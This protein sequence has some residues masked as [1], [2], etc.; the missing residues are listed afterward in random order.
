MNERSTS[1]SQLTLR[2]SMKNIVDDLKE[3]RLTVTTVI[4]EFGVI[5]LSALFVVLRSVIL[6]F[7]KWI[8]YLLQK[9]MDVFEQDVDDHI[10]AHV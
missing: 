7:T 5:A 4:K 2:N 9:R 10:H 8:K 1:V 6:S 3:S